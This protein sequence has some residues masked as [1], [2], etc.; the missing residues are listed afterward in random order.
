MEVKHKTAIEK[1][2]AATIKSCALRDT[3]RARVKRESIL[4]KAHEKFLSTS[5]LESGDTSKK[6]YVRKM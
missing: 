4:K 3:E 2:S 5:Q 1:P 6:K